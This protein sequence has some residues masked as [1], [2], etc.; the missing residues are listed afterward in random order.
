MPAEQFVIVRRC[1]STVAESAKMPPPLALARLP[2]IDTSMSVTAARQDDV[3]SRANKSAPPLPPETAD[4]LDRDADCRSSLGSATPLMKP[5]V[6]GTDAPAATAAADDDD[7]AQTKETP[8]PPVTPTVSK[9]QLAVTPHVPALDDN[10]TTSTSDTDRVSVGSAPAM[11]D[12]APP[13]TPAEQSLALRLEICMRPPSAGRLRTLTATHPPSLPAELEVQEIDERKTSAVPSIARTPPEP[14]AEH[15]EHDSCVTSN[16]ASTPADVHRA[17]PST[18]AETIEAC[19]LSTLAEVKETR[20][21]QPPLPF[22]DT[23]EH[24]TPCSTGRGTACVKMATPDEAE[25]LL[26]ASPERVRIKLAL[27]SRAA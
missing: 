10:T 16:C 15:W 4:A 21:M 14:P 6:P 18:P 20:A 11:I 26:T 2:A 27:L 19:T 7:V 1:A 25:E 23:F 3:A 5:L 17:A 9:G 22:A 13:R 8:P 24:E 12:T